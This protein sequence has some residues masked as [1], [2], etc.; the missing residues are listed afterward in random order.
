MTTPAARRNVQGHCDPGFEAVADILADNL[1]SGREIGASI[2]VYSA[3]RPVVQIWSGLADLRRDIAWGE[4]TVTPIASI[5][6]RTFRQRDNLTLQIQRLHSCH[7]Q[8]HGHPPLAARLTRICGLSLSKAL[9]QAQGRTGLG[10][11]HLT[12][13]AGAEDLEV[14]TD[15]AEPVL[16]SH[17]VGPPLHRRSGDLDRTT[18][19]AADQMM[20]VARRATAICRLTLV[21]SDGVEFAYFGHQ[22]Q[23]PVDR[24]QADPLSL[25]PKV[26][27]NLLCCPEVVAIG[28]DFLNGGPLPGLALSTRRLRRCFR[29][30]DR[31]SRHRGA[32]RRIGPRLSAHRNDQHVLHAD[33]L[34]G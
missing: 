20:M 10:C 26:V 8:S 3:G 28:E 11:K 18:A 34:R 29:F 16:R 6:S 2:G 31:P 7:V 1:R 5:S 9:R 25:M 23:G 22:L 14:V 4:H 30:R 19:N 33:V 15:L 24:G 12:G 17:R 27:V 32:P 21:G 13:V